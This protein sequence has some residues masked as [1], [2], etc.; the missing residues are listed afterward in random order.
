MSDDDPSIGD[1][2][3]YI[4][5]NTGNVLV[6][7]AVES[8]ALQ[9]RLANIAWEWNQVCDSRMAP[10][11]AGVE[12][13]NL[14][15]IRKPVEHRFDSSQIVRLM[16]RRKRHK[17][18]KLLQHLRAH[19]GRSGKPGTAM[20]N[21]M[22]NTDHSRASILWLQ[23]TRQCIDCSAGI[24]NGWREVLVD[25]PSAGTIFD[26]EVWCCPDTCDPTPR[27]E[28]PAFSTWPLK[29]GELQA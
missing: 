14:W 17:F 20:H 7:Q 11:K 16:Q 2:G 18:V 22:A 26:E 4:R 21:A 3:S 15:H 5:Q 6:R 19:H 13:G 1:L 25:D 12:A 10:M 8:I 27:L 9:V 28:L 23:P 24:A 29:N